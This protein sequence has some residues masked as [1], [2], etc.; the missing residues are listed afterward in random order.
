MSQPP[1][2]ERALRE[3]SAARA[4]ATQGSAKKRD[5]KA[6]TLVGAGMLTIFAS[7]ITL[8]VDKLSLPLYASLM[9]GLFGIG[10]AGAAVIM[11]TVPEGWVR[12]VSAVAVGIAVLMT[13]TFFLTPHPKAA[14]GLESNSPGPAGMTLGITP[15]HG[16]ISTAFFASGTSCPRPGGEIHVY[17]DGID[18]FAP[19]ICQPDH[20]Y[21]TSFRPQNGALHWFGDGHWHWLTLSPGKTYTV[22]ATTVDGDQV[23]P[24]VTYRVG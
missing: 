17:F 18:L 7:A 22:Y 5:P 4:G 6:L 9:I 19:A 16:R 2:D 13:L 14:S 21:R 23:S 12:P 10:L 20:T 11:Q 3:E 24:S 1:S 8:F 15:D